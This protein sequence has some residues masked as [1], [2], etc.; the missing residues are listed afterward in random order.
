MFDPGFTCSHVRVNNPSSSLCWSPMC[1]PW[2]F[3]LLLLLLLLCCWLVLF[4]MKEQKPVP[5]LLYLPHSG[6]TFL[7]KTPK[8][9]L[10][11]LS[12]S[13]ILHCG[14]SFPVFHDIFPTQYDMNCLGVKGYC[15]V[16]DSV[17][18]GC[19]YSDAYFYNY[20][21][22]NLVCETE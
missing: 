18:E 9:V 4:S 19:S 1:R 3:V 14:F 5:Q 2:S 8:T 16:V 11:V 13:Y 22:I 6:C 10:L 17:L 7:P 20:Y 12:P 15:D 21:S